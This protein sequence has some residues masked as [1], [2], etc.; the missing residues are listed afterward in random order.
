MRRVDCI[1][2]YACTFFVEKIQ[3]CRKGYLKRKTWLSGSPNV[4]KPCFNKAPCHKKR[5]KNVLLAAAAWLWLRPQCS[6]RF[7]PGVCSAGSAAWGCGQAKSGRARVSCC[8]RGINRQGKR[9]HYSFYGVCSDKGL[10]SLKRLPEA[11]YRRE[12]R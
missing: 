3:F 10:F 9:K 4:C 5:P 11:E 6:R 1:T 8:I 7:R 12:S 2:I